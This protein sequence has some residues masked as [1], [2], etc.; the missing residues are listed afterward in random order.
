[1]STGFLVDAVELE[2]LD[3]RL[4]SLSDIDLRP[5]MDA[6]GFEGEAQTRR[7]IEVEKTSPDGAP[8][9]PNSGGNPILEQDGHLLDSITYAVIGDDQVAWGSNRIYA[10]IHQHGGVI[11]AKDAPYLQFQVN[12]QWV[13]VSQVEIPARTYLGISQDNW[14]DMADII[15][16]F[17]DGLI[18]DQ[19]NQPSIAGRGFTA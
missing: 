14:A 7:R 18:S 2:R 1:M 17:V 4:R 11:K 9:K 15:N 6:L 13:R 12:G 5:L 19:S 16:D 3:A 8:W 10:A